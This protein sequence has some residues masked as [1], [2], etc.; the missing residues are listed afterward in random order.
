MR[1]KREREGKGK[2]GRGM[3]WN[4]GR[5]QTGKLLEEGLRSKKINGEKMFSLLI[6]GD[7]KG[8]PFI[9]S[10]CGWNDSFHIHKH[11]PS[12]QVCFET[13]LLTSQA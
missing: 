3:E 11:L 8:A 9:L 1:R 7:G 2:E 6:T 10:P 5:L 13:L 4:G 12:V